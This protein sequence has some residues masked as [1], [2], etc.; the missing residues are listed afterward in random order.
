MHENCVQGL[1]TVIDK[2]RTQINSEMT[3]EDDQLRAFQ[4]SNNDQNIAGKQ[5]IDEK[6]AVIERL[7]FPENM[8][9]GHRA[10]MRS[11]FVRF[12]RL[13]YLLDFVT[14]QSLG[15]VYVSSSTEFLTKFSRVADCC[16]KE[17]ILSK[18]VKKSKKSLWPLEIG[19]R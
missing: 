18:P 7:G 12:L 14:V 13:A 19:K 3:T 16:T 2:L 8:S 9:Y 10:L 1:K 4:K 17:P 11:E 5:G 6:K 15:Q